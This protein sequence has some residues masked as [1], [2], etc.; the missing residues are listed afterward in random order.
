MSVGIIQERLAKGRDWYDFLW[1]TARK[2]L[3]NHRLL[4]AAL[5]QIGPWKGQ[6]PKTD[7]P[8]CIE[9][10]GV[11]IREHDWMQARRDVQRFIKPH[12]LPSLE[13]PFL[14]ETFEATLA[15]VLNTDPVAPRQLNP[16]IPRDLETLC[17][18][19]LEKDPARPTGP[20]KRAA[21]PG[22]SDIK[23]P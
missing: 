6:S 14:A 4:S 5:V 1:Y 3:I 13:P 11:L 9:Q 21:Y 15:Q 10:L 2:T 22:E 16:G 20:R 7:D 19:Y 8:W 23:R 18:K 17:L 12:E